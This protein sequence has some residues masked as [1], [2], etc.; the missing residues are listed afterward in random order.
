M[1]EM[2]GNQLFLARKYSQ[3][4]DNL[5]KAL[6]S[7]PASK[8]IKRK[9]IICYTQIGQI[10][11]ALET[12]LSLLRTDIE[13]IINIDPLDDDCPCLELVREMEK[14]YDENRGSLDYLLVLGM[15]WLYCNFEKS[16]QYFN[17]AQDI[18]PKNQT[19]Q[20]IVKII[21]NYQLK[22]TFT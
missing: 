5:E 17:K 8:G 7:K 20:A 9:L 22:S 1:H 15:L 11:R 6:Q 21:N 2:L 4:T 3:A 12:F 14:K 13:F 16:K 10:Q 19:V 18:V